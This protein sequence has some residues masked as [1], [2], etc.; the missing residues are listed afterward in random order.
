HYARLLAPHLAACPDRAGA[1]ARAAEFLDRRQV[2]VFAKPR[3]FIDVSH[4]VKDDHGTGIPRVVREIVRAAYCT[5]RADFEAVAV[6]RVGDQL[7]PANRWLAPQGLLL[8]HEA[9]AATAEPVVFRPGDQLLMLDSS[10][11]Q[12]EAFEPIFERARQARVPVVTA[13]YDLLPITLPPG[14][15][16]DGGKEWFEGWVRSAIKQSDG[17][18]C[19]SKAVAD[20]LIAYMAKHGLGREGLK[21]GYW[22]LGSTF[23]AQADAPAN[24][25]ARNGAMTPYALMVGTIEP[26]KSHALALDA[27]ERLWAQGADL[28]LVIAGRA[29]WMVDDLMDR[30]RRH[31]MLNRKLFLFEGADDTEIAHLYRNAAALLFLSKGEGFGLP[32]VEAAHYGT[33]IICSDLPVFHEIAGDHATYVEIADPD[34]L[35]R[36]IAV[37]RD[38]FAAGTVPGSAG[39]TRLTW[40]ESADSLIDILVKNTWYWV[41]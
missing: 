5:E 22:H 19:I 1:A 37:W 10:W 40:K 6:E 7:V 28:S 26:R 12:Y 36:E 23:P 38:R 25:A 4:I 2:P 29:G 17:L 41:K 16:V 20:D 9:E 33:P 13:V 14:N 11:A 15:I 3:L 27:F 8:R 21:V 30:M 35:A 24:S 34:R 39:M 18:V 32:L 31:K